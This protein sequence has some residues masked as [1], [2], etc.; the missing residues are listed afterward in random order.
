MS[1]QS[2]IQLFKYHSGPIMLIISDPPGADLS[3]MVLL[4][5]GLDSDGGRQGEID[6]HRFG[7]LDIRTQLVSFDRFLI[8]R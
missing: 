7:I 8:V 1:K 2:S 4:L 6:N 3:K 5:L